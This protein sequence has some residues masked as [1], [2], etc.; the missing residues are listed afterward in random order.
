MADAH[1]LGDGADFAVLVFLDKLVPVDGLF[2]F[3]P[4]LFPYTRSD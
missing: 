4:S 2:L 1:E 3:L